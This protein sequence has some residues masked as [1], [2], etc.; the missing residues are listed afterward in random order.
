VLVEP[1]PPPAPQAKTP[2]QPQLRMDVVLKE[3]MVFTVEP[4]IYFIPSRI[5][6]PEFRKAFSEFVNFEAAEHYVQMAGGRGFGGIRIEDNVVCTA[7]QAHT[8]TSKIPKQLEEV[9]ALVGTAP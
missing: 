6:S 3:G 1:P 2:G 8:L 4:G 7:T 5:Y 9:E